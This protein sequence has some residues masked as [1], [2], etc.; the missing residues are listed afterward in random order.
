MTDDGAPPY[1]NKLPE[2][3][4]EDTPRC[5]FRF[6][7]GGEAC[8]LASYPPDPEGRCILHSE[9]SDRPQQALCSALER[10]VAAGACLEDANLQGASLNYANLQG[11]RLGGANLQGAEL[12]EA[13][14][15]TADLPRALVLGRVSLQG[16]KLQEAWLAE[17]V[18]S[19]EADLDGVVWAE[20]RKRW[21]GGTAP[22][23]V[24]REERDARAE[25]DRE[26]RAEAFHSV[27]RTYRQ[28]KR[29][30]QQSGQ[31]DLA[32]EFYIR[33]MECRRQH[34]ETAWWARWLRWVFLLKLCGYFERPWLV[35]IWML[36]LFLASAAVQGYIGINQSVP[37]TGQAAERAAAGLN[38]ARHVS[39]PEARHDPGTALY[40]SGV[41]ITTLGYGDLYPRPGWGR[42]WAILEAGFGV[43]L[44]ALFLVCL[45]RRYGR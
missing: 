42:A 34:P 1:V 31:Y 20:P 13:D 43:F 39:A 6:L 45:A 33:E 4:P 3:L 40:F 9:L 11:A 35:L 12:Y 18:I 28:I 23:Y 10:A 5:P 14:L 19:E 38:Q 37:P 30:Y 29:C 36:L 24:L 25:K 21:Y 27:E 7:L 32:G 41:T 22:S 17:C 15:R 16:A 8:G 2:G 44:M 26:W